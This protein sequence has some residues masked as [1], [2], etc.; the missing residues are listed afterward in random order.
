[1]LT[2][3]DFLLYLRAPLHLWAEKHN[4][5]NKLVPSV[6]EQHLMKQGYGV[7][8]LAHELLPHATWQ[9]AYVSDE[10][11]IRRD[12]LIKN[13]DDTYDLY[14]VKSS[15]TIKK[16][17]LYD[18]TFQSI[19]MK[20]RTKLNKI[21][22]VTLNKEYIFKNKLDIKELFLITDV[23]EEVKE[24]TNEVDGKMREAVSIIKK[25][26]PDYIEN[27]LDP[28][29]CPCIDLCYPNL[30]K[31]SIFNIPMLSPKKK[32][33]LVDSKII[34]ISDLSDQ[35]EL[36]AKQRRITDVIKLGKPYL[37][38][39]GLKTFLDSFVYPIYFLDYE[40]YPLA[41][42]IY[43]NY[44]TYQHMVFQ[45][46]LHVVNED[47]TTIHKE[48]L[49]TELGDPSRNL[50]KKLNEDI[51]DTG[52]VV[53]WNKTF[54]FERNKDMANLYPEYKEFL[55]NV[56]FRMID[57]A[58]F[59]NK[60]LYIHPDFLGSWSIKNVLP[61]MVPDLSYKK[62]N[63]NKGDQAMLAWWELIHSSDK[64]KSVELLEYCGLDTLAM[65]K[66]WEKLTI[67][68]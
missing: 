18:V 20:D 33:E 2:K 15:T 27:C 52:S 44:K 36:S 13:T 22:I 25:E 35:F 49:E 55:E 17:H 64:T 3:S 5:L 23:T 4:K 65:V 43:N 26:T 16:E 62:L 67:F 53:V 9:E 32:R 40:T 57:L 58:D 42:P 56:N 50:I 48:Y 51:G 37:N 54:E 41:V 1:M 39:T 59:I 29:T 10:F 21:F 6:Y 47:Q 30:P 12:A 7:E 14:E 60:E 68:T 61:V 38:N 28:K 34:D 8:K 24:L 66:I 63:V 31:K 46:S 19:V 45:Y 11:E